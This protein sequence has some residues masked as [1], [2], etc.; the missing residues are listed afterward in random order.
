ME[1]VT[2]GIDLTKNIFALHGVDAVGKVML[3]RPTVKRAKR[4][5]V[6][7]GLAPYLTGMEACS[8]AHHWAREM[9]RQGH[10]VRLIAPKFVAPYR[11]SGKRDK[12]DAANAV[13]ICEAVS[14][15]AMRVVPVKSI[16]QQSELVHLL[17][18]LLWAPDRPRLTTTPLPF[19]LPSALLGWPQTSTYEVT[20]HARRTHLNP[21]TCAA[22]RAGTVE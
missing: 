13:A 1:I 7:G 20:H 16:E 12:N 2:L 3:Q 17:E 21:P 9:T 5:A 15:P 6:T 18:D 11:M 19:S 4:L 14:R 10:T 8:G 22:F